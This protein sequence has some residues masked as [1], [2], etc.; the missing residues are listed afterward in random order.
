MKQKKS[1]VFLTQSGVVAALYVALTVLLQP[2]GFGSVQCRIS[3][4]LTILPVYM[5]ASIPG[6]A[7]GCF[8][9]NLIGLSTG[10][11]PA[12]ALDLLLGTA[13]TLMA[14][15]LTYALRHLRIGRLPIAATIPPVLIN[16][17]IVGAELYFVYGG[18][19]L[20]VHM[21]LVGAGQAI[22]CVGGGLVLAVAMQKSGLSTRI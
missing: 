15:L 16:A 2:I 12:G 20:I 3:E 7:V 10:A 5:P 14:A 19:P 8:L 22:A 11:N 9:S 1:L 6:L 21:A 18:M 17:L 4:A 13:A